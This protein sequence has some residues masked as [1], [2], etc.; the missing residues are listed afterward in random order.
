MA[1]G[2]RK[3]NLKRPADIWYKVFTK[4]TNCKDIS[5]NFISLL[6][7]VDGNIILFRFILHRALVHLANELIDLVFT[8][9]MITSL[10]KVCGHLTET[11]LRRAELEWP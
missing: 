3:T 10:D 11:T 4:K 5:D 2:E 8:V 9:S 1:D 7:K 6:K